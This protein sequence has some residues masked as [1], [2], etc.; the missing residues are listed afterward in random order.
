MRILRAQH[1]ARMLY[2]ALLRDGEQASAHFQA[3]Q[4]SDAPAASGYHQ[5][6]QSLRCD[7]Q[8]VLSDASHK[9]TK[10]ALSSIAT[11]VV[12]LSSPPS[13]SS[14]VTTAYAAPAS[15]HSG[16]SS[17]DEATKSARAAIR[18]VLALREELLAHASNVNGLVSAQW[19]RNMSAFVRTIGTEVPLLLQVCLSMFKPAGAA[20]VSVSVGTECT[21]QEVEV[22]LQGI[23]SPP[24]TPAAVLGQL[25]ELLAAVFLSTLGKID[26]SLILKLRGLLFSDLRCE[27]PQASWWRAWKR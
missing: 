4:L 17:L 3:L 18:A 19:V 1:T 10:F 12:S 15:K 8:A 2:W 9:C 13:S 21:V 24:L 27:C 20:V 11:N 7:A 22:L 6:D 23:T 25:A 14:S 26:C 16:F 5:W